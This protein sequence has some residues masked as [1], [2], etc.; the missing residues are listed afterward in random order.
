MNFVN[1]TVSLLISNLMPNNKAYYVNR[2]WIKDELFPLMHSV[3]EKTSENR[4]NIQDNQTAHFNSMIIIV[5]IASLLGLV[6]I[7]TLVCYKTQS[8]LSGKLTNA[9]HSIFNKLG[10]RATNEVLPFAL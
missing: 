10:T 1:G 9:V 8:S 3:N 4:D 6:S 5:D 7:L 2:D